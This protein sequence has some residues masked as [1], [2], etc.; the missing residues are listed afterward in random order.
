VLIIII[1]LTIHI[2]S[3]LAIYMAGDVHVN[4]LITRELFVYSRAAEK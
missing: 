3:V 4:E 1:V 2:G